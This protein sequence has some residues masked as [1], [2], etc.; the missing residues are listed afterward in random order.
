MK[1]AYS[2]N[3]KEE[4]VYHNLSVSG[5]LVHGRIDTGDKPETTS[6]DSPAADAADDDI[7]F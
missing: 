4:K 1:G 2:R 6:D 3:T 5:I 7:P